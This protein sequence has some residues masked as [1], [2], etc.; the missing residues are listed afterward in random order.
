L[1][2]EMTE[3]IE[4]LEVTPLQFATLSP[5]KTAFWRPVKMTLQPEGSVQKGWKIV[6]YSVE[7]NWVNE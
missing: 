2:T 7:P 5:L 4:I 6:G 1:N 3:V